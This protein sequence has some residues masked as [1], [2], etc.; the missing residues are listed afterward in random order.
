MH[1]ADDVVALPA[2]EHYAVQQ[3]PVA[4]IGDVEVGEPGPGEPVRQVHHTF[5]WPL[6]IFPALRNARLDALVAIRKISGVHTGIVP[7][8]CS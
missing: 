3:E 1:P 6:Q 2:I 8:K 4:G 5:G 7:Q